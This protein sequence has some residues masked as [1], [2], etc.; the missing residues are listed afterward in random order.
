MFCHSFFSDIFV[1]SSRGTFLAIFKNRRQGQNSLEICFLT[2][3]KERERE[4]Q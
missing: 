3:K 1:Y 2:K 4:N